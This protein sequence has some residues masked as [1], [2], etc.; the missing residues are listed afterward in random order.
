MAELT[1]V[2]VQPTAL[3][4]SARRRRVA[5]SQ[6]A[7]QGLGRRVERTVKAQ[8]REL[9]AA[10]IENIALDLF[11]HRGYAN[12]SV[13]DLASAAGVSAR[14]FYRYFA[15]KEDVLTL[16]PKRLT[17]FVRSA[18]LEEAV[19]RPI[20]DAFSA[21]LMKLAES[22]DLEELRRWCRVT[23]SDGHSYGSMA[24][25]DQELREEMEPL[26]RERFAGP[27]ADSMQFDLAL[28]AGQTAIT[29]AAAEWF[30][31]GGDFVALVQE[32]LDIFAH[33]FTVR[34]RSRK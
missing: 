5:G 29:A 23:S 1:R 25:H 13:E 3:S 21:V 15:T 27:S 24:L 33:G 17:A 14:T 16:Y 7:E 18:L 34:S 32:A 10:E 4:T 11:V 2:R 6:G 26:F 30:S 9:M 31:R 19:G 20:F 22:M 8:R 28:R 12:V